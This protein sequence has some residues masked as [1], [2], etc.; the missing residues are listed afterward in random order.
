L[1]CE[2]F[3]PCAAAVELTIETSAQVYTLGQTIQ[4]SLLVRSSRAF[5]GNV[6]LV[7]FDELPNRPQARVVLE[8]DIPV[9]LPSGGERRIP[10]ALTPD[11]PGHY[12]ALAAIQADVAVIARQTA[13]FGVRPQNFP[14][15]VP[16]TILRA[17][18]APISA[19]TVRQLLEQS[20]SSGQAVDLRL[21]PRLFR[22]QVERMELFTPGSQVPG[23]LRQV[24]VYKG[25][26]A[27]EPGSRAVITVGPE[28]LYGHNIVSTIEDDFPVPAV[29]TVEP[30]GNYQEGAPANAHLIYDLVD[31]VAAEETHADP[32]AAAE[33][34]GQ[35]GSGCPPA[36]DGGAATHTVEKTVILRIY[37]HLEDLDRS[38]RRL[39]LVATWAGILEDEF[40]DITPRQCTSHDITISG[41]RI[42]SWQFISSSGY[43]SDCEDNIFKFRNDHSGDDHRLYVLFSDVNMAC[44]GIGFLG[45]GSRTDWHSIVKDTHDFNTDVVILGQETGHNLDWHSAWDL[46]PSPPTPHDPHLDV[47]ETWN[48]SYVNIV[49]G[50]EYIIAKYCTIMRA[51]YDGCDQ[52]VLSYSRRS[53]TALRHLAEG[54][55]RYF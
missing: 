16:D 5:N 7:V 55:Y 46:D 17:L 34:R 28:G 53:D 39:A 19:A 31:T 40:Q 47:S 45:Q 3:A 15:E 18:I 21:G 29:V 41:V 44:G 20:A 43:T 54:L 51:S 42:D 25:A 10:F 27:S 52:A 24:G 36:G 1:D 30:L 4:G 14:A 11:H 6:S 33:D 48:W 23:E 22:V 13:H 8:D 2:S 32:I 50:V 38:L 35:P 9:S 26:L 12:V 37:E 49:T